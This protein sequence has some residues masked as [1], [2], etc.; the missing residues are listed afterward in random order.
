MKKKLFPIIA[1]LA[2]G[3]VFAFAG[4]GENGKS[5]YDLWLEAGNS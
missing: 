1:T 4:C 3:A 2:L 5:A